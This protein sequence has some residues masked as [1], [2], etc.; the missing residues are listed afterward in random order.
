VVLKSLFIFAAV[1]V[2]SAQTSSTKL[3]VPGNFTRVMRLA[4]PDGSHVLYGVPFRESVNEGPQLWIENMRTH[5]RHML[6]SIP[7]TLSAAW[8]SDGSAFYVQ[9]HV[10]SDETF[11]FIY[12]TDTLRRLDLAASILASDP[13]ARRFADGHAHFDVDGWQGAGQVIVHFYGHTD[14]PPVSS[15]DFRYQ[16]SRAGDVV[17]LSQRV[18]VFGQTGCR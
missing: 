5:R 18:C 14:E 8:A 13:A 17:K 11:S 4:S 7:D 6:L 1:I 16:V 3:D 15:F 2:V 9:D 10:A 12:D